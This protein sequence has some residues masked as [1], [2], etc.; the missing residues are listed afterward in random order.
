M[1]IVYKNI[2]LVKFQG[3]RANKPCIILYKNSLVENQTVP[4]EYCDFLHVSG[5][6][7]PCHLFQMSLEFECSDREQ[8]LQQAYLSF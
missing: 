7:L 6:T 1:V 3:L 2:Y 8:K 5:L 4:H